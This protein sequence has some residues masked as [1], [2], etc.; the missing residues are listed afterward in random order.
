[1]G[2]ALSAIIRAPASPLPWPQNIETTAARVVT[3]ALSYYLAYTVIASLIVVFGLS[4]LG[5]IA[6]GLYY[7]I[8]KVMAPRQIPHPR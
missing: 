7:A 4:V 3:P 8:Q 6:I 2:G 1:M 5:G